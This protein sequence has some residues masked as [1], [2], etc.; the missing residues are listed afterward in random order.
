MRI[1][2]PSIASL[3]LMSGAGVAHADGTHDGVLCQSG[4]PVAAAIAALQATPGSLAA[5]LNVADALVE[6]NCFD[7]AVH[8]LEDG[9]TLHPRN[10]EL[11]AK[12]R[13]TRSL[14]SEQ[15]YFA[16]REQAEMAARLA[17]NRLRC[18][19]LND[20]NA[21]D[22]A[23]KVKPDDAELLAA[24]QAQRQSR[25][26]DDASNAA[27][28][29]AAITISDR[30]KQP[31]AAARPMEN[32]PVAPVVEARRYSNAEEPTHSH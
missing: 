22:E 16:G 24:A 10:G 6:A 15:D 20:L 1:L 9:E 28:N 11:Q 2:T 17:R 12:L 25:S 14:A 5:R 27:P 19:K 4:A 32:V 23:L 30:G 29:K 13:T 21:C 18:T 31:V 26:I 8:T 7:Q 3:F